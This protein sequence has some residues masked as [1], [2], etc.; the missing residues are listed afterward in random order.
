[1]R[2]NNDGG[3]VFFTREMRSSMLLLVS[4]ACF[5]FYDGVLFLCRHSQVDVC[6]S[7]LAGSQFQ[8]IGK[9][10]RRRKGLEE[11][12]KCKWCMRCIQ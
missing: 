4:K 5:V 12:F 2:M 8:T 9:N 3:F 7:E 10:D 11:D 1:M 6:T